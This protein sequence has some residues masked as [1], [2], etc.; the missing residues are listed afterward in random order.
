MKMVPPYIL[1]MILLTSQELDSF[2]SL[3]KQFS[4]YSLFNSLKGTHI[5]VSVPAIHCLYF[6]RAHQAIAVSFTDIATSLIMLNKT[7]TKPGKNKV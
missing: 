7:I 1:N 5:F 3:R 4:F 6:Q 2:R